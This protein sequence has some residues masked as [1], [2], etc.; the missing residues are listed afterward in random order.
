M[1]GVLNR[2]SSHH[3]QWALSSKRAVWLLWGNMDPRDIGCNVVAGLVKPSGA[4]WRLEQDTSSEQVDRIAGALKSDLPGS[5]AFMDR[6]RTRHSLWTHLLASQGSAAE[7][8]FQAPW[9]GPLYIATVA[10]L[11]I[12]AQDPEACLLTDQALELMSKFKGRDW[13]ERASRLQAAAAEFCD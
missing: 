3:V 5:A 11:A 4:S 2:Y 8:D 13:R 7:R 6:F 12:D 1:I 10:A 9:N